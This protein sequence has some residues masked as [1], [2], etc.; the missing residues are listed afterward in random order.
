M[1]FWG[2]RS[3]KARHSLFTFTIHC[4]SVRLYR[5]LALRRP[6]EAAIEHIPRLAFAD[7]RTLAD[8]ICLD[9]LDG[10]MTRRIEELINRLHPHHTKTRQHV[11]QLLLH[12]AAPPQQVAASLAVHF[13]TGRALEVVENRQYLADE[14]LVGELGLLDALLVRP[15]TEVLQIGNRSQMVLPR[16]VQLRLQFGNSPRQPLSGD[17]LGNPLRLGLRGCLFRGVHSLFVSDLDLL[18]LRHHESHPHMIIIY[19]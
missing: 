16:L 12:H 13:A 17:L 4:R 10:L 18:L 9:E 3:C 6:H 15:P 8:I 14:T 5:D 11:A 1:G 19:D 7:D 2:Q